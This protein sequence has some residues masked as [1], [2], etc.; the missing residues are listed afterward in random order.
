MT[1]R[2]QMIS[3]LPADTMTGIFFQSTMPT[4]ESAWRRPN[5]PEFHHIQSDLATKLHA[6]LTA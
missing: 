6:A 5:T 2:T 1:F 3:E 4:M